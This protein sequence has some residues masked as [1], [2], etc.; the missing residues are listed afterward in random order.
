MSI[1]ALILAIFFAFSPSNDS[2][3]STSIDNP[4]AYNPQFASACQPSLIPIGTVVEIIR[5]GG[6]RTSGTVVAYY[7]EP[8][9]NPG[10]ERLPGEILPDDE[11]VYWIALSCVSGQVCTSVTVPVRSFPFARMEYIPGG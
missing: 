8:T 11:V 6:E 10:R 9:A 7:R 3:Q 2:L 5:A 1:I 4:C